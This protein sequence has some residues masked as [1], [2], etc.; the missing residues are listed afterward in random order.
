VAKKI[1]GGFRR[2]DKV[3]ILFYYIFGKLKTEVP[4]ENKTETLILTTGFPG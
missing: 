3:A 1:G 2:V 4:M